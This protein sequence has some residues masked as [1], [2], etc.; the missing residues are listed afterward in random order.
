MITINNYIK[1]KS[2]EEAYELNQKKANR[3]V[4]GMM[5]LRM[6]K[7]RMQTAID[8]SELGLNKIE[9]TEEEFR[10]GCMCTL[11]QLELHKGLEQY[12]D[13]AVRESVR[14]I[15]GTQFRNGATVGGSI[16]GRFGFSDVLT[17]FLGMD[18]YVEL[19]KGGIIPLK[20]Y[21]KMP[22]DRDI[23]VRLIVKKEKA[24][25]DYQS[26]RNSQTDFPV[27]TCAAAKTEA[28]YRFSIGARPGKAV[29]FELAA[30]D[31]QAAD[32]ENMAENAAKC[33]KEQVETGSNT[34]GSAE[35]RK[36]LAGVL[37]RRA[38]CKLAGK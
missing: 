3:I 35:Y 1:V 5:W 16:F 25:F 8:L 38:V 6:S 17:M 7:G 31:I 9:E 4:G 18:S 20:E 23:L 26:V 2:L 30:A 29:L 33:V 11:R 36:H 27:L 12:F 10:I 19:Y 13:G 32:V 21:A 15:V 22:Y 14:R 37:V 28:G 34:R 24:A